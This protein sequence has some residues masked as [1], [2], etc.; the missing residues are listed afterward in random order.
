MSDSYLMSTP[1]TTDMFKKYNAKRKKEREN[2]ILHQGF[3]SKRMKVNNNYEGEIVKNISFNFHNATNSN[4]KKEWNCFKPIQFETPLTKC[5]TFASPL[6]DNSSETKMSKQT[7]RL[8]EIKE[9]G[10]QNYILRNSLFDESKHWSTN[11]ILQKLKNNDKGND[12]FAKINSNH[13]FTEDTLIIEN[14]ST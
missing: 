9:A 4:E 3:K 10:P 12:N 6:F 2:E 11:T 7:S 5:N 8:F 14:E 13:L 1:T